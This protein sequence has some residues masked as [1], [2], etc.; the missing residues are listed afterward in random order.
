LETQKLNMGRLV[1]LIHPPQ[2]SIGMMHDIVWQNSYQ[3]LVDQDVFTEPLDISEA[4]T[5]RF[6]KQIYPSS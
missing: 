5:L 6:L 4:Y 2:T 3:T 1:P